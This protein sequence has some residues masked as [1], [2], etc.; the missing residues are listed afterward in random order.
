MPIKKIFLAILAMGIIGANTTFSKIGLAEFP[1]LLFSFFRFFFIFPLA[2]F[3][4]RPKISW[5]LLIL[6]A[7]TLG[8]LHIALVN[9]GLHLG[10]TA[11]S[12]SFI[13]QSG[14]LFAILFAYLILKAKPTLFDF[15]GI[16]LGSFGLIL[17]FSEKDLSGSLTSLSFC[18]ASA[19]MW[20]LGYTL[21]KKANSK[22]L[23]ITIW[24]SILLFPFLA[25]L[26]LLFEDNEKIIHS[27]SNASSTA[28]M[29]AFFSSWVSMLGAGGILMYLMQTEE[30]A[31]VAPFNMLI[32]IFGTLTA[33]L[34]LNEPLTF[35]TIIGGSWILLGI[36]TTQFA[37]PLLESLRN[38]AS[39]N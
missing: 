29:S 39:L 11:A 23:P 16:A 15:L 28:W 12:T 17:V 36:I 30:I 20:G 27:L 22:A 4:P 21:V 9:V 10:A 8:C 19:I 7:L 35:T 3:I 25:L 6:I 26:S 2:F 34:F 18:L 31:K 13:I 5:K 38:K 37:K 33:F 1:P 14:S 24:M 32:P